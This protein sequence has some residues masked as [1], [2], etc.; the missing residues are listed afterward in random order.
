[1]LLAIFQLKC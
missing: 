1:H